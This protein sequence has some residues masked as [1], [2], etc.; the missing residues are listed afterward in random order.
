MAAR[1]REVQQAPLASREFEA[2]FVQDTTLL[3]TLIKE[4]TLGAHA[5]NASSGRS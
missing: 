2:R 3:R 4:V 1:E 5:S